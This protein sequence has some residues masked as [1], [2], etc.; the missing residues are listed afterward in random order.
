MRRTSACL[1]LLLIFVASDEIFILNDMDVISKD[2]LPSCVLKSAILG[3][4]FA[5]NP[6]FRDKDWLNFGPSNPLF[7]DKKWHELPRPCSILYAKHS[8]THN[9]STAEAWITGNV[10][11]IRIPLL[12]LALATRQWQIDL[13]SCPPRYSFNVTGPLPLA[14]ISDLSHSPSLTLNRQYPW[15]VGIPRTTRILHSIIIGEREEDPPRRVQA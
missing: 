14:P 3:V 1:S 5:S 15:P 2:L 9:L 10:V 7:L 13:N 4:P 8:N 12:G 11:R 6:L